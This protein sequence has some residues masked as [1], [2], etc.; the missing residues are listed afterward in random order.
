MI[1]MSKST[2]ETSTYTENLQFRDLSPITLISGKEWRPSEKELLQWSTFYPDTDLPGELRRMEG[3][4]QKH[5][6]RRKTERGM[7]AFVKAWLDRKIRVAAVSQHRT[8]HSRY[9][10]KFNDFNL[11]QEYDFEE[12]E[13]D[14][15]SISGRTDTK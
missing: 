13:A 14:L 15:L 1:M 12:L 5:P 2:C 6:D 8:K 10:N 11:R 7:H 3:W 4:F 9:Q